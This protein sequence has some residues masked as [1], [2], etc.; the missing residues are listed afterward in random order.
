MFKESKRA[1]DKPALLVW[2]WI[3]LAVSCLQLNA[4]GLTR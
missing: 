1:G 4:E 2:L 3:G